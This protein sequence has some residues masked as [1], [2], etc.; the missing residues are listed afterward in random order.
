MKKL[1]LII[2]LLTIANLNYAVTLK[3]PSKQELEELFSKIHYDHLA[4]KTNIYD[5]FANKELEEAQLVCIIDSALETYKSYT[6]NY[7][8]FYNLAKRA[9]ITILLEKYSIQITRA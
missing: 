6:S 8:L 9:I 3:L 5:K 2:C 7:Q 1:I 4:D